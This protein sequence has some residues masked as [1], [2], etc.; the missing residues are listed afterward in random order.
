M[1][2]TYCL[3]IDPGFAMLGVRSGRR[4]DHWPSSA[5]PHCRGPIALRPAGGPAIIAPA[6]RTVVTLG[7]LESLGF[8]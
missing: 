8:V 4:L 1:T 3:S 5:P 6:Y 2:D 7:E